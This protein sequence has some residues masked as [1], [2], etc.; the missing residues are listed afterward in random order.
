[1]KPA[2]LLALLAAAMVSSAAGQMRVGEAGSPSAE[3]NALAP[4]RA[5]LLRPTE[6]VYQSGTAPDIWYIIMQNFYNRGEADILALNATSCVFL[7]IPVTDFLTQMQLGDVCDGARATTTN[8]G[9]TLAGRRLLA[10]L[11]A[12]RLDSWASLSAG[13]GLKQIAQAPLPLDNASSP[14]ADSTTPPAVANSQCGANFTE[15]ASEL[16]L[17]PSTYA[18]N[19]FYF[20]LENDPRQDA[21]LLFCLLDTEKC[22][23]ACLNV[24]RFW[25]A[26]GTT[27]GAMCLLAGLG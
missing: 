7:V 25:D 1:M 9:P 15:A 20:I 23:Q 4:V 12:G 16:K 24:H 8:G 3:Q 11:Q 10:A 14:P 18:D 13:R 6:Q 26:T 17:F 21:T 22:A 2:G 5:C 27:V 19:L